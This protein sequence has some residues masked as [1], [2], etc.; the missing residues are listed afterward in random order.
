MK[1]I[2]YSWSHKLKNDRV[3]AQSSPFGVDGVSFPL[4]RY[5]NAV[6]TDYVFT[7]CPAW[8]HKASRT[9]LVKSP[10]SYE[11]S[12]NTNPVGEYGLCWDPK[13]QLSFDDMVRLDKDWNNAETAVIQIL[14]PTLAMWTKERNIWYEVRPH[15]ITSVKNNF[16]AI[17]AWFNLST[18]QRPSAFGM[19]IYDM[20]KPVKVSRGD[21]LFEVCF[22]SNNL[23]DQFKLVEHP[24]IPVKEWQK[25]VNNVSVKQYIT[26]FTKHL[27]RKQEVSKCPFA[28]LFNK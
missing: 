13:N 12:F 6:D 18:W 27:F 23:D 2:N 28:F 19:Q 7:N 3:L 8:S 1:E 17:G 14:H 9:F 22:Y 24:E 5:K 16:T 20:S 10:I 11:F 21:V 25:M 15:A 26:S 4:E